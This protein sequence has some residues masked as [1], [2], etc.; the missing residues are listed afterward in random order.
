ML[1]AGVLHTRVGLRWMDLKLLKI[2]FQYRVMVV[3]TVWM[4]DYI[5][6]R[7]AHHFPNWRREIGVTLL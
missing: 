6:K 4:V 3:E 1:S 5:K 7:I 2:C